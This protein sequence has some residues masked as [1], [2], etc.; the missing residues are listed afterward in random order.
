MYRG[1]QYNATTCQ[2]RQP[3]QQDVT[4]YSP[5]QLRGYG[6]ARGQ[7][8]QSQRLS[9]TAPSLQFLQVLVAGPLSL[10][11][12]TDQKGQELF[13]ARKDANGPLLRLAQRDTVVTQYDKQTN[14][15]IRKRVRVYPFRN[16]LWPLTADC[17]AVQSTLSQ[18]ELI[19]SKLI[20]VVSAYNRCVGG[21]AQLVAARQK[22]K[23]SFSLLAGVQQARVYYLQEANKVKGA[24]KLCVGIGVQLQP[25]RF[26]SH[27][28][29][30]AQALYSHERY[31]GVFN[32]TIQVYFPGTRTLDAQFS[33]I[34]LPLMFR[35][36]LGEGRIRPYLQGG[37]SVVLHL[38]RDA[39]VRALLDDNTT[40]YTTPI[41]LRTYG[42]GLVG[43]VGVA[44]LVRQTAKISLESRFDIFDS[45]SEA[46][47]A[48]SGARSIAVLA[49]YTFGR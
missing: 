10:Y 14:T 44:I 11:H 13:F 4:T 19:E 29:V 2:F 45:T 30:L 47:S 34:R 12:F 27:L 40:R 38:Q 28:S 24:P 9:A 20:S 15:E 22:T 33:S 32:G 6:F 42:S 49:G 43:G 16:V 23:A 17:P 3:D 37:G 46:S 39:Q 18:A 26:N 36:T 35:Y 41:D 21:P 8:Y 5:D 48:L 25:A 31:Q 1:E 7:Q